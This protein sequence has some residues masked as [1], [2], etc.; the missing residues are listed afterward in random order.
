MGQTLQDRISVKLNKATAAYIEAAKRSGETYGEKINS[1]IPRDLERYYALLRRARAHVR[2][3]FDESELQMIASVVAQSNGHVPLDP[4]SLRLALK[5]ASSVERGR[6]IELAR[7]LRAAPDP[8]LLALIDA[9][10][11]WRRSPRV[12]ILSCLI[13]LDD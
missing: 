13:A 2:E 5:D 12:S 6:R 1:V 10:E 4:D 7:R 9:L 11:Q 8:T 3:L